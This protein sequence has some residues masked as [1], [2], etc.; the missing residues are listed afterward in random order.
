MDSTASYTTGSSAPL[1]KEIRQRYQ[2]RSSYGKAFPVV[3][4]WYQFQDRIRLRR[5]LLS[6]RNPLRDGGVCAHERTLA[7]KPRT[8]EPGRTW[9]SS[10]P[11]TLKSVAGAMISF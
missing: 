7:V 1:L 6:S 4:E 5:S 10:H 8:K 3:S 9:C 2:A 11:R